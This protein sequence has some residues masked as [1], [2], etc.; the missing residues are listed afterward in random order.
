MATFCA[1]RVVGVSPHL[2]DVFAARVVTNPES[3]EISG[4]IAIEIFRV[5]DEKRCFMG[6][7]GQKQPGCEQERR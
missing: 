7:P 4:H 3:A 5:F 2:V 6:A 1:Q